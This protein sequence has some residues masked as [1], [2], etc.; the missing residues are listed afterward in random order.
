MYTRSRLRGAAAAYS[1]TSV[2]DNAEFGAA[3][4]FIRVAN[5]DPDALAAT[6]TAANDRFENIEVIHHREVSVPG[7]FEPVDHRVPRMD[8]E[9]AHLN[10]ADEGGQVGHHE[11]FADLPT[12]SGTRIRLLTGAHT[13][14]PNCVQL[15]KSGLL[16][17]CEKRL[18]RW[19]EPGEL[20]SSSRITPT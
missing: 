8:L 2:A 18:Q 5:S 7:L 13:G 16:S 11:V 12:V 20:R 10:E 1:T 15:L 3:S 6:L 4:H 14:L 19:H 17:V 9:N